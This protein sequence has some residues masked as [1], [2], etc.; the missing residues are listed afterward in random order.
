M[1]PRKPII[2]QKRASGEP[3]EGKGIRFFFNVSEGT[4]RYQISLKVNYT[5]LIVTIF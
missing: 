1:E 5:L 3:V 2:G 4:S